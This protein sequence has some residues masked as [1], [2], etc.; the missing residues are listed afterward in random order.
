MDEG[1][2]IIAHINNNIGL[3]G[4]GFAAAVMRKWP[5]VRERYLVWHKGGKNFE[6]GQ[7]QIVKA[8]PSIFVANMIGQDGVRNKSNPVPAYR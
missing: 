4:S 5:H 6:G 8:E 1:I 3:F 7:I 2:R